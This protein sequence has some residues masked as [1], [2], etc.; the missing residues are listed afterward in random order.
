[1]L[2]CFFV[3]SEPSGAASRLSGENNVDIYGRL[4]LVKPIFALFRL[5]RAERV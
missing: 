4:P 1:M 2:S 3:R 5:I